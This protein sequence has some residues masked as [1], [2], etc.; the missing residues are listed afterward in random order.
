MNA[1]VWKWRAE[2]LLHFSSQSLWPSSCL[3][4]PFFQHNICVYNK[5]EE[6]MPASLSNLFKWSMISRASYQ[7]CWAKNGALNLSW[8]SISNK[9][10]INDQNFYIIFIA[11]NLDTYISFKTFKNYKT[12]IQLQLCQENIQIN[13]LLIMIQYLLQ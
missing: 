5:Y 6:K 9:G 11:F 12:T 7:I 4:T 1:P 13:K 2:T 10:Y 8:D 3:S